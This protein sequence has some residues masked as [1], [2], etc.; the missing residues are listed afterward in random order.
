MNYDAILSI[1]ILTSS[2]KPMQ[3]LEQIRAAHALQ[4][5]GRT[6]KADVNKIPAM[7]IANGL[8]AT[9]AF[10]KERKENGE[11]KRNEMKVVM[12]GTAT[13]LSNLG[14]VLGAADSDSLV[15][16]LTAASSIDLQRA[17]T[18]SLAFIGFVKRFASKEM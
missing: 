14:I 8:L 3:N 10:C 1:L 11:P 17:T 13:H 12:D 2:G 16:R 9:T 4:V 15:E 7:I 18:E 6:T 5:S